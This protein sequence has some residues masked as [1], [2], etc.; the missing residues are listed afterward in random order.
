MGTMPRHR[1]TSD[2]LSPG[3]ARGERRPL[4]STVFEAMHE[5][6]GSR[7]WSAVTMSDV[8]KA[9]GVSKGTLYVYFDSKEAVFE[10]LVRSAIVPNLERA[11]RVAVLHE[12][13]V[14]PLLHELDEA[15]VRTTVVMT[16]DDLE[17][18][19]VHRGDESLRRLRRRGWTGTVRWSRSTDCPRAWR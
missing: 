7:D 8:A 6:L 15:A 9:A 3:D 18:Y 11:E 12:G 4:R 16:P 13:P 14:G 1:Q 2:R 5:L 17:H 19:C 10:A